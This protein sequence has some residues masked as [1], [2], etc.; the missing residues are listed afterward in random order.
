MKQLPL[1][2]KE[3]IAQIIHTSIHLGHVPD[4]WKT[5]TITMIPK[6]KNNKRLK[7]YGPISL[8]FC[9]GK[10]CESIVNEDLVNPCETLNLNKAPT[11]PSI[12]TKRPLIW[13]MHYRQSSKTNGKSNNLL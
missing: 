8:A 3:T 4:Q 13:Q 12:S 6:G 11:K 7:S 10:L 9:L 5:S 1:T 2:T